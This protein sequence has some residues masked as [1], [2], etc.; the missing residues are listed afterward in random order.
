MTQKRQ[1]PDST[2]PTAQEYFD[3]TLE[4]FPSIQ[5]RLLSDSRIVHNPDF[6][7]VVL[8]VQDNKEECL[9]LREK[10][11]IESLLICKSHSRS[12]SVQDRESSGSIVQRATKHFRLDHSNKNSL[13]IDTNILVPTSNSFLNCISI[14]IHALTNNMKGI[15]PTSIEAQ[16]FS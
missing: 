7:S 10:S 11:A 1:S 3:A 14:A 9:S 15:L 12:D 2:P 5:E 16:L 8:K 4:E 13:Y 6:G